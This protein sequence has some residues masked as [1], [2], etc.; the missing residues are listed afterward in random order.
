VST[1]GD[2]ARF[3]GLGRAARRVGWALRQLP[4][5]TRVPWHRVINS[6]G[7]LALPADSAAGRL[8]RERLLREGVPLR[9]GDRI[10]LATYRWRP[11][12]GSPC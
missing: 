6:A 10:A 5:D 11:E 2:I 1:Y 4:G 8:Q 7:K 9:T 3:A 12:T